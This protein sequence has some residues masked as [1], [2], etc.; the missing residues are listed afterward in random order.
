VVELLRAG[1]A[2]IFRFANFDRFDDLETNIRIVGRA[3]GEDANAEGLIAEMD[4]RL[5]I[6]ATRSAGQPRPHVMSYSTDGYTAGANTLFD[7]VIRAAG[8]TNA[9]SE[10]GV[11]G[12]AKIS[13]E[14]VLNWNPDVIIAGARPG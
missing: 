1:G 4:R 5:A 8:G 13:A 10:H 7:D 9:S 12:F 6:L 2:P 3:I 11:C 14:Q